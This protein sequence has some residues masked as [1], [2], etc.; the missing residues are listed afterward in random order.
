[1]IGSAV[2]PRTRIINALII[3]LTAVLISL[4]LWA[5]G[6]FHGLELKTWDW[7]VNKFAKPSENTANI[8]LILVDQPSVDWAAK[9]NG[10]PWPWPRT[11]YGRLWIF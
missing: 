4:V 7:R 11:A 2:N 3:A 6:W 1:M 5:T 10:W 9:E 8:C